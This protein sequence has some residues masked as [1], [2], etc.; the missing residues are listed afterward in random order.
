[1]RVERER[2]ARLTDDLVTIA[3]TPRDFLSL[4]NEGQGAGR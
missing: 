4:V 2:G 1:M 3:R